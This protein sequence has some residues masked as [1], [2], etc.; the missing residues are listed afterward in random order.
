MPV[1]SPIY[2]VLACDVP[3]LVTLANAGAGVSIRGICTGS[4]CHPDYLWS[5]T[6]NLSSLEKQVV[7][8]FTSANVSP[9]LNLEKLDLL[10]MSTG[11]TCVDFPNT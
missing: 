6:P 1:S 7:K 5:V 4:L 9:T 10:A 8:P 3:L 2:A 11:C